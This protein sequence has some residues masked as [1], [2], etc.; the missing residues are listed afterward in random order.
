MSS[1]APLFFA[2]PLRYWRWAARERPAYFYSILIGSM[3]PVVLFTVPPTLKALGYERA[4]PIPMTY[5]IPPGP[6][7]QLSGYDD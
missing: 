6:R 3:G 5:P 1:R 4:A 2:N 7:K